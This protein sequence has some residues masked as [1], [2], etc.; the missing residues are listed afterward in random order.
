MK[1]TRVDIRTIR[2]PLQVPIP[3]ARTLI[4]AIGCLLV[5]IQTD[6]GLVGE[7]MVF[8][9][10][11]RRLGALRELVE[12]F[13]PHA[14]G[15]DPLHGG[16]F[17]DAAWRDMGFLGHRG[18]NAVAAAPIDMAMWDLRGKAAGVNVGG[19]LGGHRTAVP[20][21]RSGALRLSAS[22]DALQREAADLVAEGF[23]AVK[24]S[25]GMPSADDDVARV[26]AVREAI[27]PGVELMADCNQQFTVDQAI[28][29]GRR[30][31]PHGLRWI[32]EPL[33][34]HDHAG[35]AAVARALDTPVAGGETEYTRLGMMDMLR[36]GAVDLL[37]PDLQRMGGPTEF[38]KVAHAAELMNVPLA[39]HLFVE[40]NLSL[41][42]ALPG[43]TH[44]EVMPWF[45]PLYGAA[46]ELDAQGRAV[47]P[48]APGWGFSFDRAAVERYSA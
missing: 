13:A 36:A 1:V 5:E 33:P 17:W 41:A 38:L 31:E 11:S 42:A 12:S 25:L 34:Y 39:P 10:N 18:A 45:E 48:T 21:Y 43:V 27:G 4:E 19:L 7:G 35:T 26:R 47:V 44:V 28:R 46:I 23:R 2:L 8:T 6:Q 9:L 24:M 14:V 16:A 30:L 32:E 3:S 29:L 37:M 22:V 20:A 40:M 15:L